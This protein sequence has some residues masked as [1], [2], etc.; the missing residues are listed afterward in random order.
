MNEPRQIHFT[1][2]PA[3]DFDL[4]IFTFRSVRFDNELTATVALS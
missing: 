3:D 4:F 2:S 1:D